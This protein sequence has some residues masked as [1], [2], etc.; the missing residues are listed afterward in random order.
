MVS[1]ARFGHSGASRAGWKWAAT[2]GGVAAL[3]ERA[4]KLSL[5]HGAD[6]NVP[7]EIA[8]VEALAAIGR[9]QLTD[10]GG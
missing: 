4:A 9:Y 2:S 6:K 5:G 10:F 8:T 7:E 3:I 1:R